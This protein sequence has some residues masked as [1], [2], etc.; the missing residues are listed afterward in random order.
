MVLPWGCLASWLHPALE[1]EEEG[2]EPRGA[3]TPG[4]LGPSCPPLHLAGLRTVP[5]HGTAEPHVLLHGAAPH[6]SCPDR[7]LGTGTGVAGASPLPAPSG[8]GGGCDPPWA[9]GSW[10]QARGQTPAQENAPRIPRAG[11]RAWSSLCGMLWMQEG[12]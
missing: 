5:W 7:A 9:A 12:W 4:E 6:P 1:E 10:G 2:G 11:P 3:G 8:A